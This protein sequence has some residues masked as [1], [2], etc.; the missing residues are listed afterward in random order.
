MSDR[1]IRSLERRWH[2]SGALED[3]VAYLRARVSADLLTVA[4]LEIAALCGHAGAWHA[5]E[6]CGPQLTTLDQIAQMLEVSPATFEGTRCPVS[7]SG[8][9][10][11]YD[12]VRVFSWYWK[13]RR[14]ES[15]D[16][17]FGALLIA[18]VQLD[19]Q[20]AARV[21]FVAARAVARAWQRRLPHDVRPSRFLASLRQWIQDPSP[22]RRRELKRRQKEA[23]HCWG[24]FWALVEALLTPQTVAPTWLKSVLSRLTDPGDSRVHPMPS[25]SWPPSREKWFG[26]GQH[27]D[28]LRQ[29]VFQ[30]AVPWILYGRAPEV[31]TPPAREQAASRRDCRICK[32]I[33]K[34]SH[35]DFDPTT[36]LGGFEIVSVSGKWAQTWVR[37]CPICATRYRC[38]QGRDRDFFGYDGG[39][40]EVF[41]RIK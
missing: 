26:V 4:E 32:R 23:W 18:V 10:P 21:A 17:A 16:Q 11:R 40:F 35:S 14:F 30:E 5:R 19:R 12:R 22:P 15:K 33:K 25:P 29:A 8:S 36:N 27:E 2:E 37:R 9:A 20:A 28:P 34:R 31:L 6:A 1:R 3:E 38:T 39:P 41:E 13:A 7:R 24:A